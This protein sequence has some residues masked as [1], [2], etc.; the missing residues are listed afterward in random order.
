MITKDNFALKSI[1]SVP[2]RDLDNPYAE[3]RYLS[4]KQWTALTD[5]SQ[6]TQETFNSIQLRRM[7]I[8]PTLEDISTKIFFSILTLLYIM[9]RGWKKHLDFRYL[10]LIVSNSGS[11]FEYEKIRQGLLAEFDYDIG[12]AV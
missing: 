6:M 2:Q 11:C 7:E 10:I 8:E 5:P 12:P 1:S 4:Q 3:I 9:Q